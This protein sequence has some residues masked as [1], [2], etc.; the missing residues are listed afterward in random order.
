[1]RSPCAL[2]RHLNDYDEPTSS[3]WYNCRYDGEPQPLNSQEAVDDFKKLCSSMYTD[4]SQPLCCNGEQL[5]ILKKDLLTA[6]ALIGS[7]SSCYFNFRQLWCQFACSPSQADFIVPYNI[8]SLPGSNFTQRMEI[9]KKQ[10]EKIANDDWD[11]GDE[12]DYDDEYD[13]Y[14]IYGAEGSDDGDSM[15]YVKEETMEE[16]PNLTTPQSHENNTTPVLQNTTPV[17][18]G[19]NAEETEAYDDNAE[20]ETTVRRKKRSATKSKKIESSNVDAVIGV[21]YFI[22]RTFMEEFV[23]SCR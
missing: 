15:D 11:Y 10:K 1:M 6:Q 3:K 8:T 5:S 21:N 14:E 4:D 13:N 22:D 20:E 9:Y 18:D 12:E 2:Q 19:D 16:K 17:L 23:D 7:C